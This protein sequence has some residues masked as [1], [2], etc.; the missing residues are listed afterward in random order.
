MCA[1]GANHGTNAPSPAKGLVL[2]RHIAR[3]LT[4][5]RNLN[6]FVLQLARHM[7]GAVNHDDVFADDALI[8]LAMYIDLARLNLTRHLACFANLQIIGCELTRNRTTDRYIA[9]R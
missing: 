2:L 9:R 5:A 4:A 6:F 3:E 8:Q 1:F 7:T